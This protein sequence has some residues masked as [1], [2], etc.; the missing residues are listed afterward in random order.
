MPIV[1]TI[2]RQYADQSTNKLTQTETIT[3]NSERNFDQSVPIAA[4]TQ[5]FLPFTRSKMLSLAIKSDQDVT[6]YTN[7]ASS[8]SPTDTITVKAGVVREWSLASNGL[9]ACPFT[10]DVTSLY[11]TNASPAAAALQIRSCLNQT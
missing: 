9:A 4:N 6:I 10:A 8:G 11:V 1:H 2:T 5:Y 7:A 3:G